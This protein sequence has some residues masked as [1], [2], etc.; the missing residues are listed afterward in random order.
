M[1]STA[2][3]LEVTFIFMWLAADSQ[4]ISSGWLRPKWIWDFYVSLCVSPVTCTLLLARCTYS[5]NAPL[6]L[7]IAPL[8]SV[9]SRCVKCLYYIRPRCSLSSE[10]FVLTGAVTLFVWVEKWSSAL[11]QSSHWARPSVSS[12][13]SS[14][15]SHLPAVCTFASTA[16][17]S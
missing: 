11:E 6:T 16:T 4:Q 14:R 15:Q 1:I 13:A 2:D 12:I 5:G 9:Q 10:L 7:S 17:L 3:F 8:L